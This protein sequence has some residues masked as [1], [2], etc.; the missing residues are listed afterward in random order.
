MEAKGYG[1]EYG[2]EDAVCESGPGVMR[3]C[4]T[5]SIVAGAL[6]G[7]AGARLTVE[8]FCFAVIANDALGEMSVR[9]REATVECVVYVF[10]CA[11]RRKVV[12]YG[13]HLQRSPANTL[14]RLQPVSARNSL[15]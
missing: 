8:T 7:R 5:L 13:L 4:A 10:V 12:L 2:I 3:W 15:H 9:P 1:K 11:K 14:S 6:V